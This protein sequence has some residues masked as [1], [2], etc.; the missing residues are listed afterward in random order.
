MTSN[1][2]LS[3]AKKLDDAIISIS[4]EAQTFDLTHSKSIQGS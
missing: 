4:G 1:M 3:F 2:R